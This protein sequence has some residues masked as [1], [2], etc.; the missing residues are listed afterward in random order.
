MVVEKDFSRF[1]VAIGVSP[2]DAAQAFQRVDHDSAGHIST[3]QL[4]SAI[5]DFY[6]STDPASPGS[7]L[8]G[9]VTA[10]QNSR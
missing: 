3:G 5:R 4:S 9:E 8:M 10:S 7:I 2:E 1:F 6:T